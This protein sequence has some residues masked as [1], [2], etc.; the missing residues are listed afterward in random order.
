MPSLLR[1]SFYIEYAMLLTHVGRRAV[2]P[3]SNTRKNCHMVRKNDKMLI[4]GYLTA[5]GPYASP[6]FRKSS[7]AGL[8][9]TSNRSRGY[10]PVLIQ[11]P[12]T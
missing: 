7:N 5:T 11:L 1:Q 8:A 12:G 10:F 2:D 6:A 3:P 9:K 4:G